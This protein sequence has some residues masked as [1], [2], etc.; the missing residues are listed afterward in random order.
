MRIEYTFP[1]IPSFRRWRFFV[2]NDLGNAILSIKGPGAFLFRWFFNLYF[3][4]YAHESPVARIGGANLYT[5][6]VP[7]IPSKAHAHHYENLLLRLL[8]KKRVPLAATLAVTP[9]CQ[10]QCV[11]CSASS[12]NR[13]AADTELSTDQWKRVVRESKELG[14]TNITFTGGE[15]LLRPDLEEIVSTLPRGEAV[16]LVFTNGIGLTPERVRS[17]SEA[18][19]TGIQISLDSPDPAEH[20]R[21]RGRDGLFRAVETGARTALDAGLLV[22]LSTYATRQSV[23]AKQLTRMAALAA[24]WGVHELTVFDAMPSGRLSGRDDVTLTPAHRTALIEESSRLRRETRGKLH[25]ITQSWTNCGKGFPRIIGCLAGN[26]QFHVTAS[27]EFRPCDFTPWSFGNVRASSVED[28]WKRL[29]SHPAY[30]RHRQACRMQSPEFRTEY[31]D[32]LF[33]RDGDGPGRSE[34]NR[35]EC[36]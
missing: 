15:P 30:R 1:R 23:E 11:H 36:A 35:G 2:D 21:L 4:A 7:P 22:G 25:L 19:L 34:S 17:L 29:T 18:G 27:G 31:I 26:Y 6:Y 13:T 3:K 5:L 10:L 20:D 8:F 16:T 9:K 14:A 12:G 28:L 32:P 24:A 33:R